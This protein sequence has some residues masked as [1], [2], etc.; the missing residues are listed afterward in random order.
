MPKGN[1]N[2]TEGP[3]ASRL[4][5]LTWPMML[6]MFGIVAFNLIDTY[7]I[8]K[9]GLKQLAAISFCFPVIMFINSL[10]Q[11]IGVGTSSLISRN[12]VK[13]ERKE[14]RMMAS[15][16][17]VLGLII[18]VIFAIAGLLTIQPLFAALGAGSELIQYIDDYMSIWYYGAPFVMMPMVGNHIVRATGDT[19]TPGMIMVSSAIVNAILDPLLI[20][21]YGP[22][23]EMGIKGAA[24]AT[25]IA[26]SSSFLIILI[27]LIRREKLLTIYIGRLREILSTWGRVLYIAGPATLSMLI[28][29]ISIGLVTKIISGFGKEAVAGFG[30]ASRIEMFALMLIAAL[31]S[32]MIIFM[33]QNI[34]KRKYDRINKALKYAASFSVIW[35]FFVFVLLLLFAGDIAAIF[36]KDQHVID[37]TSK[38]LVVVGL[39]YGFQGLVMLSTA[40]FNGMNK[41]FPSAIF[42]IIR[43]IG[44]Y[45]PLAW[46]GAKLFGLNAVFWA[47]FTANIIIGLL[48]F[49][50]LFRTVK[51]EEAHLYDPAK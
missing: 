20:F 17:I 45:V 34:S 28:T 31:G 9:L 8:G 44:L 46:L 41:P 19:F 3:I 38:Y 35:G 10:S 5:G 36:S 48:S 15:R 7:F 21:G 2:L 16:T 27:V 49:S 11:G 39:S 40:S 6:G 25:V 29:P 51:K 42:S 13:V 4:A 24:V 30:V 43:M 26:R 33:G 37:I 12:I 50:F 23:P 18:I 22:F 32:V 47:A 1:R 14:V